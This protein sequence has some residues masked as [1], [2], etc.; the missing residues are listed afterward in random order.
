MDSAQISLRF[1]TPATVITR[2]DVR[3]DVPQ[4][5]QA[6]ITND[7]VVRCCSTCWHHAHML[8]VRDPKTGSLRG[9]SCQ[10]R[11]RDPED[12]ALVN[13]CR[14]WVEKEET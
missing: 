12:T 9:Y 3:L 5:W 8:G 10:H 4:R 7:G 1:D 2:H 13:P 11:Q 6:S 14:G